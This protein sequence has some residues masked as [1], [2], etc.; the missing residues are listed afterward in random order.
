MPDAERGLDRSQMSGHNT[1]ETSTRGLK[2]NSI[3]VINDGG[4]EEV[5]E[6]ETERAEIE[7][8]KIA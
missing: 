8:T 7:K 3:S 5:K 6:D 1:L 2:K 4:D